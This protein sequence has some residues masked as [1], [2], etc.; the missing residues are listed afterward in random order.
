MLESL[1][2]ATLLL[3]W[4]TPVDLIVSFLLDLFSSENDL[5]VFRAPLPH[6][7][8]SALFSSQSFCVVIWNLELSHARDVFVL[9]KS[10]KTSHG[11]KRC[12][13][14]HPWC[15]WWSLNAVNHLLRSD[16][17]TESDCVLAITLSTSAVCF[18]LQWCRFWISFL[19]LSWL[20]LTE[21]RFLDRNSVCK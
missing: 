15:L 19:I 14:Y 16:C 7:S 6:D 11:L 3:L 9:I 18:I 21:G 2:E 13:C 5:H 17:V 8:T 1:L 12:F 20:T 4:C 10:W